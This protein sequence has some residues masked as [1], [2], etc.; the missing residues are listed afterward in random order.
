M[1]AKDYQ[2]LVRMYRDQTGELEVDHHEFAGWAEKMGV[3]MPKA[4]SAIDLLA[5]EFSRLAR[6]V[7]RHDAKT[8]RPYRANHAY[9]FKQGEKQMALWVDI[10]EAPR[11]QMRKR[12]VQKREHMVGEALQLSFDM[13]HWNNIHPNEEPIELP[14]D[15]GPD[16]E[17]RKNSPDDD[18]TDQSA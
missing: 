17:W 12:L 18:E 1:K 2:K 3:R 8:G 4:P 16:V 9:V 5:K 14:L 13:E 6:E 15:L 7:I 10:D 11:H